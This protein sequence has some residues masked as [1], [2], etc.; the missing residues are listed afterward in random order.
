MTDR[1]DSPVRNRSACLVAHAVGDD[2]AVSDVWLNC[3]YWEICVRPG[4]GGMWLV[5]A[6]SSRGGELRAMRS[7]FF[8]DPDVYLG[9]ESWLPD[10]RAEWL[11]LI[12]AAR[13]T[14]ES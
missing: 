2:I 4:D 5:L 12:S 13:C 3:G 10:L 14:T 8:P 9:F 1:H 6:W 11:K 7:Y